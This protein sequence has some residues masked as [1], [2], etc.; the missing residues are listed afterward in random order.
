MQDGTAATYT[1]TKKL[2]LHIKTLIKPE[3]FSL[4][5]MIDAAKEVYSSVGT[6]GHLDID[7]VS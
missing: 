3:R 1:G 7:I 6:I 4:D 5:E 2:Y